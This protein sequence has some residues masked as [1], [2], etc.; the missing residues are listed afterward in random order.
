MAA[1][2]IILTKTMPVKFKM[3]WEE[4]IIYNEP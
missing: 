1:S 4:R 3:L 2:Q